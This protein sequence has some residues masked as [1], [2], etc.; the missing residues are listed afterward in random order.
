MGCDGIWEQR[1]HQDMVKWVQKQ[2]NREISNE[3]ILEQL[4]D[5]TVADETQ[6]KDSK[7]KFGIDILIM[8]AILIQFDKK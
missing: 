8:S 2:M 3:A 4:L 7:N 5:E 1:S 6:A